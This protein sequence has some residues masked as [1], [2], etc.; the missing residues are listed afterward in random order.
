MVDELGEAGSGDDDGCS[1]VHCVL[2]SILIS[3]SGPIFCVCGILCDGSCSRDWPCLGAV[4]LG[5]RRS[6]QIARAADCPILA[7]TLCHQGWLLF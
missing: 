5:Q 7:R 2:R 1:S 3:L 4:I 6:G